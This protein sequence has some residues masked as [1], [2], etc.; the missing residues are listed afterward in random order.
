MRFKLT[1]ITRDFY[2]GDEEIKVSDPDKGIEIVYKKRTNGGERPPNEGGDGIVVALCERSLSL[3]PR[4]IVPYVL[5]SYV[6]CG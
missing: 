5:M 3:R 1:Y 6:P 2:F 4:V